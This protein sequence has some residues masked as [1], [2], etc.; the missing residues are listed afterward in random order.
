[1][2]CKICIKG[3]LLCHLV[4]GVVVLK[5]E[6]IWGEGGYWR[7]QAKIWWSEITRKES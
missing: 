3:V 4:T 5:V 6:G 1:M 2:T 7:R